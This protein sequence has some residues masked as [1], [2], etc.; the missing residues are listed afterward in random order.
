MDPPY[1]DIAPSSLIYHLCIHIP[2]HIYFVLIHFP[3][4]PSTEDLKI[5]RAESCLLPALFG[6]QSSK[7]TLSG[8]CAVLYNL[9]IPHLSM[10]GTC[11]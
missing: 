7:L 1:T 3:A 6:R 5:P 11:G 8:P 10:S 9:P 4:F 2:E